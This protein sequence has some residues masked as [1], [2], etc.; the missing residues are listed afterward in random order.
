MIGGNSHSSDMARLL[1]QVLAP[2][3]MAHRIDY[4]SN[5]TCS[6][7][8]SLRPES[9]NFRL[10]KESNGSSDVTAL[11][12]G[13]DLVAQVE[14]SRSSPNRTLAIGWR[15]RP[16]RS[17]AEMVQGTRSGCSSAHDPDSMP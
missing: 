16:E 3:T 1:E 11:A 12:S 2:E 15:G 9:E 8:G 4:L 17:Y 6:T 13:A 7:S 5:V 14:R 10:M